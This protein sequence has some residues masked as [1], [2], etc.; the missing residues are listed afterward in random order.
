[1]T[2]M[3]TAGHKAKGAS[4]DQNQ[5]PEGSVDSANQK[6]KTTGFLGKWV[7]VGEPYRK[8]PLTDQPVVNNPLIPCFGDGTWSPG[9]WAGP[10]DSVQLFWTPDLG[11]WPT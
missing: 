9:G 2:T 11:P 6:R 10:Q 1:M 3:T 5:S 4:E 8:H 7:S